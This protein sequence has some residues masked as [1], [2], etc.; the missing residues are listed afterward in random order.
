MDHFVISQNTSIATVTTAEVSSAE[1]TES[2]RQQPQA[3][4]MA[5]DIPS[6]SYSTVHVQQSQAISG[7]RTLLLPKAASEVMC[8]LV[9]VYCINQTAIEKLWL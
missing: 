8:T 9:Y 4:T 2:P 6:V 5:T 3:V 1:T 7:M